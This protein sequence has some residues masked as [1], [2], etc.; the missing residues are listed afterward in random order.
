L[1]SCEFQS[2]LILRKVIIFEPRL[3]ED[4]FLSAG[5]LY[6]TLT[7]GLSAKPRSIFFYIATCALFW[8]PL[9]SMP[10]FKPCTGKAS[11]DI[12][13]DDNRC[14]LLYIRFSPCEKYTLCNLLIAPSLPD[15]GRV[16]TCSYVRRQ[17]NVL[18]AL[19]ITTG[20]PPMQIMLAQDR[21]SSVVSPQLSPC[22]DFQNPDCDSVLIFCLRVH[23]VT[24]SRLSTQNPH[25]CSPISP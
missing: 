18:L 25:Q 7:M 9:A 11:H 16:Y 10:F 23:I 4:I 5:Y 14:V 2:R 1:V 21:S 24:N 6:A 19:S 15:Q 3:F 22:K 20:T 12:F 8:L 17:D 13:M